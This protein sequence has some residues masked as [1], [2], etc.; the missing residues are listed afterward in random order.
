MSFNI[1]RCRQIRKG[2]MF[3][4]WYLNDGGR[5]KDFFGVALNSY[6]SPHS[7]IYLYN[8]TSKAKFSVIPASPRL[9]FLRFF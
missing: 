1:K 2:Q 3:M 7:L 8:Q 9:I 4:V 6:K 5:I